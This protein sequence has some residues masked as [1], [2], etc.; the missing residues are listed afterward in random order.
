[1]I[2]E[3]REWSVLCLTC[4]K[5]KTKTKKKKKKAKF[6]FS[7]LHRSYK[8]CAKKHLVR[9]T[10]PQTT[11]LSLPFISFIEKKEHKMDK[12][13]ISILP[14]EHSPPF[15]IT[16]EITKEKKASKRTI[17]LRT[18][19]IWQHWKKELKTLTYLFPFR[20]SELMANPDACQKGPLPQPFGLFDFFIGK[21]REHHIF[22]FLLTAE[23]GR[24]AEERGRK[25]ISG[26]FKRQTRGRWGSVVHRSAH[27]LNISC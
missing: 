6:S 5:T 27:F 24:Y 17:R 14:S 21:N 9:T 20:Y 22:L 18:S 15:K 25:E 3:W 2:V 10:S 12:Y 4:T 26:L 8:I 19:S 23:K 11:Y 16:K 13:D 7:V 1:M